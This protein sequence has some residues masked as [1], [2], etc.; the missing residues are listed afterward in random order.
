LA[1]PWKDE[2]TERTLI[3]YLGRK[4]LNPFVP[5]HKERDKYKVSSWAHVPGPVDRTPYE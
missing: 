3:R 1:F 2:Y 5:E 4:F